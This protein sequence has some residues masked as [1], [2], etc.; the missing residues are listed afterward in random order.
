MHVVVDADAYRPSEHLISILLAQQEYQAKTF[1]DT[2][3]T[4][5]IPK[6]QMYL[7]SHVATVT[8]ESHES[9]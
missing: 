4:D 8:M 7:C 2:V 6:T 1:A 3:G 5:I 9:T